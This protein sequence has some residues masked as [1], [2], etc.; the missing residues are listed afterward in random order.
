M[1]LHLQTWKHLHWALL[2]WSASMAVLK[3]AHCLQVQHPG[4]HQKEAE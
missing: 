4:L 2:A 3:E 1:Q